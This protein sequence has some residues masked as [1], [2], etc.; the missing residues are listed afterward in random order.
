M[1]WGRGGVPSVNVFPDA[2]S[3]SHFSEIFESDQKKVG[4]YH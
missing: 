4:L 3:Q 2:V 1:C